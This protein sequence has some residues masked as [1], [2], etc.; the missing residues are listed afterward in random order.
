MG[1]VAKA[2][3][4]THV[5]GLV[6]HASSWNRPF[7]DL[8]D[9]LNGC[10]DSQN[11]SANF[12]I[13]ASMVNFSSTITSYSATSLDNHIKELLPDGYHDL[14]FFCYGGKMAIFPGRAEVDGIAARVNSRIDISLTNA[15]FI[16]GSLTVDNYIG[17]FINP[18]AILTASDFFLIN[19]TQA[20]M[21]GDNTLGLY[22]SGSVGSRKR[23]IFSFLW[24]TQSMAVNHEFLTPPVTAQ[25]YTIAPSEA[26][27]HQL[28]SVQFESATGA[29][30]AASISRVSAV[31]QMFNL[32]T[33]RY[34]YAITGRFEPTS[35]SSVILENISGK[36]QR[37]Y[38]VERGFF[39]GAST[40]HVFKGNW[41]DTAGGIEGT[42]I[43][44]NSSLY[45]SIAGASN[46][47]ITYHIV[48]GNRSTVDRIT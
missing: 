48:V 20:S 10:L 34:D 9:Q 1:T 37:R 17:V 4:L 21:V 2:Y 32:S 16:T 25:S 31:V 40:N 33:W 26:R 6:I 29:S 36:L 18:E 28:F 14:H 41:F 47:A 46:T 23:G 38:Y 30:T 27:L 8:Y 15:Q 7:D 3:Y 44:R 43:F 45:Y 12:T 24:T 42:M 39:R 11:L 35:G 22:Y 5:D 13:D 19:V